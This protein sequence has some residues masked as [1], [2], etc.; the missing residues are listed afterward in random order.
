M[1]RGVTALILIGGGF[2]AAAGW[3][4][5]R[6]G[7]AAAAPD[8]SIRDRDIAFYAARAR[9][10]PESAADLAQLAGLF[11]QRGRETGAPAD[12]R[13]AEALARRSLTLR[14][15][16]NA[17]ALLVRASSLLA[18]HRFVEAR[19]VARE[20]VAA[21]PEQ[22]GYAALRGEIELELGDYDAARATFAALRPAWR[23]L[24]VAPRLARWAEVRGRTSEARYIL[25]VALAEA[26]RRPDLSAEQLAWFHVRVGDL[27]LRH[28]RLAEADRALHDGLAV[29]PGDPRLLGALAR[30]A[31]ARHDWRGV[32][33]WGE[34]AGD[35]P[36]LATLG[37]VGDAY[38]A[39]GDSVVAETWWAAVERA[40]AANPEPFNRQWTQFRL[41]HGRRIP[42][43]LALLRAEIAVRRDVLGYDQL[44][45]ALYLSGDYAAARAA[46][47]QALRMGTR[48]AALLAHAAIIQRAGPTHLTPHARGVNR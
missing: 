48:D 2:L 36:D 29:R 8:E 33:R 47:A 27:E 14:V 11:L 40:A 4:L 19:A 18:L 17:R 26:R 21:A 1:R 16:R 34:R 13:R 39:L 38:A 12:F 32:I 44:A 6:D 10:D 30:L 24:A 7:A 28:G 43:T 20:L 15:D 46:M 41:D 25:G 23:N 5:R 45:W 3:A 31:A 9:R 42:E 22:P 35:A 37:L